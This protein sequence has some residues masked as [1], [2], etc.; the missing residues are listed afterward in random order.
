MVQN[1]TH[2]HNTYLISFLSFIIA[3]YKLVLMAE[4]FEITYHTHICFLMGSPPPPLKMKVS[5]FTFKEY[6]CTVKTV[7]VEKNVKTEEVMS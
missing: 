2:T 4:F 3:F 6:Y 5:I 1:N 7:V